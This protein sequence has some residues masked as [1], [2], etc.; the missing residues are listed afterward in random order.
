MAVAAGVVGYARVRAILAALDVAAEGRRAA[1]LDRRHDLQLAETGV[2]GVGFAPRRA[3][4][5]EDV[6]D[7]QVRSRQKARRQA[8][9]R[10][11]RLRPSRSSG[12]VMSRIVLTATR[13]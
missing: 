1:G 2:A 9:G 10:L 7:L 11:A 6:G 4:G 13:V 5:S 8:G 12:L 3:V